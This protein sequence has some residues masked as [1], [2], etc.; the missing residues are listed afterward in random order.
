VVA[1]F[2]RF[3]SNS[4]NAQSKPLTFTINKA[5]PTITKGG[6]YNGKPYEATATAIGVD[7]GTV[8][9]SFTY[10][11]YVGTSATGP[12][13]ST[14][15]TNE[16]TYTVVAYFISTDPKYTDAESNPLTFTI[17]RRFIR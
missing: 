6:N 1:R 8:S 12:G 7:G 5:R 10:T 14:P 13:T 4:T 2:T 11:Y 15:P 16:G 17:K 3:D 9:G